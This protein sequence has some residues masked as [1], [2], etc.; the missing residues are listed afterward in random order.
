MSL[1]AVPILAVLAF[2]LVII[3]SFVFYILFSRLYEQ[4]KMLT[5][6]VKAN[7]LFVNELRSDCDTLQNKLLTV[8]E[9]NEK[10]S[11][12]NVQVSRQLEHRIK[13][14]Q[15]QFTEQEKLISQWQENQSQDKFY[16]RA[17]RL[18]EKGAGIDEIMR[19]CELPRAEVEMLLSVY[20][21]R[22]HR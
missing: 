20:Q 4:I 8:I 18:A 5:S 21:Q 10:V 3:S 7:E 14:L 17:F 15:Q 12:E 13:T 11:L 22:T 16:S 2:F 6:E 1:L 9:S 19:E